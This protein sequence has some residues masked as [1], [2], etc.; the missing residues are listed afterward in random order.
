MC[1]LHLLLCQQYA[2][3]CLHCLEDQLLVGAIE[4]FVDSEVQVL[5]RSIAFQLWVLSNEF[6]WPKKRLA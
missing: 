5:C 2:E 1:H 6:H 4:L 3:I